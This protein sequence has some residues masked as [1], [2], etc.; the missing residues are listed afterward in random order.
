M[1]E[2][3]TSTA[4]TVSVASIALLSLLPGVDASVVLGTFAGSVV[5]VMASDDLSAVKK[6]GYFFPSFIGG[7]LSASMVTRLIESVI[8]AT[9]VVN[10]GVGALLAATLVVKTLLWLFARDPTHVIEAILDRVRK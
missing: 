2:P 9:I 1:T 4:A 7:M 8:P 5:F 3:V 6:I 10:P